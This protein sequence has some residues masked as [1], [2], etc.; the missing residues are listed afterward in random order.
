[1]TAASWTGTP[2]PRETASAVRPALPRLVEQIVAAVGSENPAYAAVLTSPEGVGLR[3]GIEHAMSAFLEAVESGER[4]KPEAMETWR[5]LGEAEFQAGRSLE[6]LRAAWRTGTRAAWRGAASLAAE[7]GIPSPT[8]IAL[9]EA[10]FVYTDELGT[11]VVEGYLRIQSD[12]AGER[13]RRRRRVLS[14]L[15]DS[16]E[17]DPEAIARA[18]EL[19]RW[20][21]PQTL[22]VLAVRSETPG[23]LTRRLDDDVLAGEGPWLLVPDPDGPGRMA[24]LGRALGS[25]TAALGPTVTPRDA[26]RSLHWAQLTLELISRG[27]IPSEHPT[28]TADHLATVILLRDEPLADALVAERLRALEELPVPERDRLLETLQA[29]LEHQRHTPSIAEAL[30]VHPQT[31]RYRIGKLKELLGEQLETPNGRFELELALR[32]RRAR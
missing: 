9:A 11:E 17:H 21:V 25:T 20:P 5:R 30:H 12:E 7:A 14:L 13:E 24:A 16:D 10:I 23:A 31:V 28:R 19:A 8:V 18:A 22:A 3:L 2:I 32:A 15:L 26:R 27:A 1:M 29:W 6:A 4:P